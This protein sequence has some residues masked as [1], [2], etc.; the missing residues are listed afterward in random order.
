M[1]GQL[2]SDNL[3]GSHTSSYSIFWKTIIVIQLRSKFLTD[4]VEEK[5]TQSQE[6][7]GVF[8]GLL[9]NNIL[10]LLLI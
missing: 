6:G 5:I 1:F 8:S 3:S 4:R 9:K 2:K 10:L 7:H